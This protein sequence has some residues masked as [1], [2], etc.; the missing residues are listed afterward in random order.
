LGPSAVSPIASA[1]VRFKDEF[2]AYT[3]GTGETSVAIGGKAY[4]AKSPLARQTSIPVAAD[5]VPIAGGGA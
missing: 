5:P 3:G 2:L 4:I 1:I